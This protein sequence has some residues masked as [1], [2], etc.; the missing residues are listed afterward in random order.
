MVRRNAAMVVREVCKHTPELAQL[1]VATGGVAALVDNVRETCGNERLPGV[2]ALGYIAAFSETLALTV[3]ASEGLPP[4]LNAFTTEVEDH[5]R[6]A[7]AWSLG[8][9]GRHSPNHAK[10]VA[11]LEV[12]PPLVGGFVSKHSSED[13]QSKCKKAVKGICDRLTFFPALNSLLQGPPLPEGILKYVLIQIAKVIPHDQEAKTLF[14]TSGSFGKMQ[15]MAVESSS[16]IKSLV[17]SVN[18]AYP[19][20][21]V[22]YYSPGYSEIL[23]QKLAGGKF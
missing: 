1:V 9:I 16:E 12:L 22:H 18:S 15:E 11:E 21:I 19:I 17:D 10:A 7:S 8:Q 13:L 3:I 5:I 6:S 23:L 4:L 14:V 20:E 2:M